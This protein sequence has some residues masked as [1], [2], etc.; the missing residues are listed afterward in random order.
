MTLFRTFVFDCDLSDFEPDSPVFK[1]GAANG[2]RLEPFYSDLAHYA[3]QEIETMNNI[4][5]FHYA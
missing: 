1:N 5:H 3:L 4:K 2:I